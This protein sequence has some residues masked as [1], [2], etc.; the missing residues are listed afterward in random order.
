[1]KRILIILSFFITAIDCMHRP[2]TGAI[3]HSDKHVCC[4]WN[5]QG[6]RIYKISEDCYVGLFSLHSSHGTNSHLLIGPRAQE[7][8][9]IGKK[10]Y[11]DI[12]HLK[13]TPQLKKEE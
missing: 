6:M 8:F 1:M 3:G 12:Q 5:N 7:G 13:N 4:F 11:E 10:L 9:A 2:H